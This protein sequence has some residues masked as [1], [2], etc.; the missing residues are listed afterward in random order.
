MA[1]K[2]ILLTGAT[3]FLGSNFLRV[4]LENGYCVTALKRASSDLSRIKDLAGRI[5]AIDTDKV[6]IESNFRNGRI[7]AVVHCATNYGRG[8]VDPVELIEANLILPLRLLNIM[9]KSGTKAFINTDTILDKRISTYSL[10]KSQFREWL[11]MFSSEMTCVNASLEHFYGPGD[12]PTKFVTSMVLKMLNGENPIRLTKG[13]Q[14]RGFLY[15]DDVTAAL[16]KILD[17]ALRLP[18]GYFHYDIASDKKTAIKDTVELIKKLTGSASAAD[19]GA[20]PYRENEIM[21]YDTDTS[22][23]K[24]LGWSQKIS[25]EEGLELT[26]ESERKRAS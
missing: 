23:V 3:G 10:S 18:A 4:L 7:D 12:D 16:L 2:N 26:I 6:D 8:D 9:K 1:A 19:L 17:N 13:E 14:K 25:L 15:V 21:V 24:D 11:K 5:S 22:A 20:L